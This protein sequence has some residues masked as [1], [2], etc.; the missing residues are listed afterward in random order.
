MKWLKDLF[1]IK[2]HIGFD[3]EQLAIVYEVMSNY[4]DKLKV[5]NSGDLDYSMQIAKITRKIKRS[6]EP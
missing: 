6:L 4:Y 1:G 5:N 3:D 2:D